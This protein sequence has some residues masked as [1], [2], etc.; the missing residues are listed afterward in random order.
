[1]SAAAV[2]FVHGLWM[3]GHESLLLR[4]RLRR[5][6]GYSTHVFHYA[7]VRAP[8]ARSAADLRAAL[9]A[10]DA[11]MVHLI[12][13]SLG[14]LV[15][16]RAL[17]GH[18]LAPPGRVVFLGTPSG[19]SRAARVLGATRL[20]RALLGRAMAEELLVARVRRWDLERP[21]GIIAGTTNAGLGRLLLSFGEANDGTVTVAET[22]LE[23]AS[24]HLCLPVTHSTLLFSARV[25]QATADF[26][27]HGTFG[28]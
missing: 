4:A 16:L 5:A 27:E 21:L 17:Q 25:A 6:G 22:K 13:H 20:G 19:G 24:G 23:G 3:S 18:P 28:T 2:V 11:P 12:G 14:G 15:I 7:S 1:M 8:I 10:L 26:L 9:A